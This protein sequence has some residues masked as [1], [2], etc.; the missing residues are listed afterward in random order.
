M[1]TSE[2][3]FSSGFLRASFL[4]KTLPWTRNLGLILR[5]YER[6]SNLRIKMNL[7]DSHKKRNERAVK[8]AKTQKKVTLTDAL[9]QVKKLKKGSTK[10]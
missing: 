6:I 8:T 3:M 10:K 2:K 5:G 7:N 9:E 1:N 4:S